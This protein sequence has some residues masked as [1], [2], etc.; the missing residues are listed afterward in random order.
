MQKA[1]PSLRT[2]VL[3]IPYVIIGIIHLVALLIGDQA[4]STFTKPLLMPVLLA[5]F[6]FALPRWRMIVALLT[7]LA[8]LF[9]W[10]GD[11]G[12]ASSGDISFLVAL[13]LFFVAHV[14]YV[15]LFLRRV[16]LSRLPLMSLLYVL[17]WIVLVVTLAPHIGTMLI[18]V[19]AYGL[20]LG[21]MGAVAM[22]CNGYIALGG[23]LFVISDSILALNKFYPDFNLWQVHFVIMLTYITAQGLIA[24]GVVLWAWRRRALDDLIATSELLPDDREKVPEASELSSVDS[25]QPTETT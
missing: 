8:I 15:I 10:A 23:V 1:V 12:M 19:M 17:W 9:S 14:F 21:A 2:T 5:G 7:S 13:G 16:R 24:M 22:G 11:V 25:E 20:I 3:F 4:L 6:L 18:P